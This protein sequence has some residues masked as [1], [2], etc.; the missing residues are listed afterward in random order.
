MSM[1][2]PT[3]NVTFSV[4]EPSLADVLSMYSMRSTPLTCCSIGAATV[5]AITCALAPG[6]TVVTRITGGAICGYCA[7]GSVRYATPPRITIRIEI[8]HATIGRRMKNWLNM[9]LALP[10]RARRLLVARLVRIGAAAARERL[11]LHLRARTR[12]QQPDDDHAVGDAQSRRHDPQ[13][14]VELA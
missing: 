4:Y 5:S 2:V 13:R 3:S 8:T 12:A 9:V 1:S 7:T 10:R 11:R 14:P 6:N